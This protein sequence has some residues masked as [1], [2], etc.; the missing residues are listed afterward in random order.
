MHEGTTVDAAR[1]SREFSRRWEG[2]RAAI[3]VA[4]RVN[5]IFKPNGS[6]SRD[7]EIC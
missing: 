1:R 6:R 3:S 2:R 5:K 7:D 4:G